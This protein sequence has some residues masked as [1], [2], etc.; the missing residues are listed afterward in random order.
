MERIRR[1]NDCGINDTEVEQDEIYHDNLLQAYY[2][3]RGGDRLIF[4][5]S[6]QLI[7]LIKIINNYN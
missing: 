6:E 1:Y 3:R 2:N 5:R 7:P 4:Y